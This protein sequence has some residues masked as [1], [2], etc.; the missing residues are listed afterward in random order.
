MNPSSELALSLIELSI[1]HFSFVNVQESGN[2]SVIKPETKWAAKM[3]IALDTAR[4]EE[5]W[6]YSHRLNVNY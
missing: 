6:S 3:R 5:I 1:C 2:I 4:F